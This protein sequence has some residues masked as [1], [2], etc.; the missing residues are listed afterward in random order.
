MNRFNN[1]RMLGKSY[2]RPNAL[3]QF[4]KVGSTKCD[5]NFQNKFANLKTK[6]LI[7][8][9]ND[10]QVSEKYDL[11]IITLVLVSKF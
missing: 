9:C 5:G 3:E 8:P 6:M 4:S 2:N 1:A 11:E 7:Y 10:P